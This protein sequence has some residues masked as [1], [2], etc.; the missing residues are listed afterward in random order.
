VKPDGTGDAPTIQAAFDSSSTGDSVLVAPGIFQ[1]H[2]ILTR[3][4]VSLHSEF[5]PDST[6]ID[7][8]DGYDGIFGI[9]FNAPWDVD[10][11]TIIGATGGG[12][13]I[14]GGGD[15]MIRGCVMRDC[16]VAL[17]A[18]DFSGTIVYVTAAGL[19]EG[20]SSGSGLSFNH[21]EPALINCIVAFNDGYGIVEW[22][23]GYVPKMVSCCCIYENQ[24][25]NY[26]NVPDPT[27]TN[28]NISEDPLFC[29]FIGRNLHLDHDS[30][31]APY[32]PPNPE[33]QLIGALP[34]GCGSQSVHERVQRRP[35]LH[36][37]PSVLGR[38][39]PDLRIA[40][41][42]PR[43]SSRS[44]VLLTIHDPAG[45]LVQTLVN[46]PQAAGPHM[47]GWSGTDTSGRPVPGGVYFCRLRLDDAQT[48]NQ[49]LMVR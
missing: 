39:T 4:Y 45:R 35:E 20:P 17:Y 21:S 32:T 33:C 47:A 31:C 15:Q 9:E 12:I 25:G 23:G 44:A 26:E 42:V 38:A 10:G 19:F 49:F 36:L 41:T 16:S 8:S 18:R 28:G 29:D 11:F 27:G 3:P 37:T 22:T 13:A 5:G 24:G 34:V 14:R 46:A 30:P 7:A 43:H 40:Y 2:D 48:L 6:T 1:E